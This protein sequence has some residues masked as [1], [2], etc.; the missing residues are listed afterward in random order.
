MFFACILSSN[1]SGATRNATI[2]NITNNLLLVQHYSRNQAVHETGCSPDTVTNYYQACRQACY[3]WSLSEQPKIGVPGMT[4]EIDESQMT[5][6]KNNVGRVTN[7]QWVFGGICRETRERFVVPVHDRTAE[8]LLPIIQ[9]FIVE[10]TNINSDSWRSYTKI[11][12]LDSN[13]THNVVN[14]HQNFVDPQTGTHTQTVER[15]WREVKRV[16]RRS[17]G[18]HNSDVDFHLA[19]YLWRCHFKVSNLNAFQM[20]IKLIAETYYY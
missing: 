6:R 16:K 15:M 19:E 9:T 3:Q 17:E 18:I 5:K 8:T 11:D 2:K 4:V 7:E 20:A 1:D 14:H 13:Y 10:G 12:Q